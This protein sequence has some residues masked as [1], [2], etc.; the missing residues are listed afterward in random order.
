MIKIKNNPKG[1]FKISCII[2]LI[3]FITS[4]A[5]AFWPFSNDEPVDEYSKYIGIDENTLSSE[6]Q[7]RLNEARKSAKKSIHKEEIKKRNLKITN[8]GDKT[9]FHFISRKYP[10]LKVFNELPFE[11][12]KWWTKYVET[13][14]FNATHDKN[15]TELPHEKS[16]RY[17]EYATENHKKGDKVS[18][19]DSLA[20]IPQNST[21]KWVEYLGENKGRSY[22]KTH[23]LNQTD[24][25]EMDIPP[26]REDTEE[27][28]SLDA[29]KI[30]KYYPQIEQAYYNTPIW[31]DKIELDNIPPS[32]DQAEEEK[33]WAEHP[34]RDN[35]VRKIR[36]KKY[37]E[38]H[39]RTEENKI[40]CENYPA[41]INGYP[42]QYYKPRS[43][44]KEN[45]EKRA[46]KRFNELFYDTIDYDKDSIDY[47]FEK[48]IF[49]IKQQRIGYI[50]VSQYGGEYYRN[51]GQW[52]N[53]WALAGTGATKGRYVGK[54][55]STLQNQIDRDSKK[56]YRIL[57]EE[58]MKFISEIEGKPI[59][60]PTPTPEPTP[61]LTPEPTPEPTLAPTPTI[62]PTPEE[63]IRK[64]ALNETIPQ[65]L[66]NETAIA[67]ETIAPDKR[68]LVVDNRTFDMLTGPITPENIQSIF[69][70]DIDYSKFEYPSCP[71]TPEEVVKEPVIVEPELPEFKDSTSVFAHIIRTG[72]F[73]VSSYPKWKLKMN[74]P[75]AIILDLRDIKR[76]RKRQYDMFSGKTL[77]DYDKD[78]QIIIRSTIIPTHIPDLDKAMEEHREAQHRASTRRF[79]N[80]LMT[81]L[82]Y[83][84]RK[85]DFDKENWAKYN[86]K[87]DVRKFIRNQI[88][89][90][91]GYDATKYVHGDQIIEDIRNYAPPK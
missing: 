77:L 23:N 28:A 39:K 73:Q 74:N 66:L 83:T 42:I 16:E 59:T 43:M 35:E 57:T 90:M 48:I 75:D 72:N 32:R 85:K 22:Y 40:F 62:S 37:W 52:A 81:N 63:L 12:G 49:N 87:Y 44:Q 50:Y 58:D 56:R 5:E 91:S 25:W 4:S 15:G 33:Y 61:E 84:L 31:W 6:E 3:L 47:K 27:M 60:T 21:D 45:I 78:K 71:W 38:A 70:K 55:D 76:L 7:N 69:Q 29:Y 41:K 9:E 8:Y 64:S 86:E 65:D 26:T 79:K 67:N 82:E 34:E 17:I 88:K 36:D 46:T 53:D 13:H 54:V 1:I 19:T 2:L 18:R 14:N 80:L 24:F 11:N 20:D 30:I 89:D 51:Y 10:T 68:I